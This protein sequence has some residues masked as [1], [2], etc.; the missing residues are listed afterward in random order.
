MKTAIEIAKA[1]LNPFETMDA[2][3]RTVEIN[4]PYTKIVFK[5]TIILYT[6]R[7]DREG[8][9]WDVKN[10]YRFEQGA[11]NLSNY[12]EWEKSIIGSVP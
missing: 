2:G 1:I 11:F 12:N 9:W 4:G 10:Y 8:N 3:Y 6:E 5:D 7:Q